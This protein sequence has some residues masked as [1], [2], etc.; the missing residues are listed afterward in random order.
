MKNYTVYYIIKANH[1]EWL[2]KMTVEAENSREATKVCKKEVFEK[3]KKNAFRPSTSIKS[4]FW[5]P[6]PEKI[7]EALSELEKNKYYRM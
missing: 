2:H 5:N 6:T 3:T 4:F 7:E 1:Q